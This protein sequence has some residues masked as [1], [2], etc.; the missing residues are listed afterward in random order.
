MKAHEIGPDGIHRAGNETPARSL[1]WREEARMTQR[2]EQGGRYRFPEHG[3]GPLPS[4]FEPELRDLDGLLR[5]QARRVDLPTGLCDRIYRASV[6]ALPQ[7]PQP[8]Q[9]PRRAIR[10]EAVTRWRGRLAVAASLGLAFVLAA[11]LV[12]PPTA[13]PAGIAATGA[14]LY[15]DRAEWF[16]EEP[17]ELEEWTVAYELDA[18]ALR[19]S[20][21]D[22]TGEIEAMIADFEM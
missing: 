10:R 18:F 8:E 17:R 11:V 14:E 4:H 5:E 22:F 21:D 15:L 2:S 3:A 20:Y 6:A 12:E 1:V 7:R 19:A 13:P 9:R 16:G